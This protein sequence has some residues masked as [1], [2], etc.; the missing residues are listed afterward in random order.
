MVAL[1]T[2][3]AASTARRLPSTAAA[4]LLVRML[5]ASRP[6]GQ[7]RLARANGTFSRSRVTRVVGRVS[8]LHCAKVVAVRTCLRRLAERSSS[9]SPRVGPVGLPVLQARRPIAKRT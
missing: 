2:P 6:E 4:S 9:S 1:G 3:L 7:R 8:L 5:K